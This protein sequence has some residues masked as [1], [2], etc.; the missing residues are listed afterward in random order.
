[1]KKYTVQKIRSML[2]GVELDILVAKA[3]GWSVEKHREIDR[4]TGKR[5]TVYE[6]HT[7]NRVMPLW[8]PS[9]E[10]TI[11]LSLLQAMRTRQ[12]IIRWSVE[13]QF[14]HESDGRLFEEGDN[15]RA[16]LYPSGDHCTA[17][18]PQLAVARVIALYGFNAQ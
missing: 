10:I 5:Y 13:S 15:Y 2:P 16:G 6:M 18:S 8:R 14:T 12:M 11:A 1:M 17:Q 9:A 3:M 7:D 4:H